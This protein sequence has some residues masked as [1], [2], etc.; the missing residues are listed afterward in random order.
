[1]NAID[2][3]TQRALRLFLD[4]IASRYP[5]AGARLYGGRGRNTHGPYSDADL[6]VLLRGPGGDSLDVG[7]DMAG[8]AF[9]VML[10]TEILV[11]PLPIWSK[12]GGARR[13]IP[14]HGC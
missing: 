2:P 11:S 3:L 8:I 7:V 13:A 10:D 14:I 6:A 5:V 12:T 4:R 1:M 9:D